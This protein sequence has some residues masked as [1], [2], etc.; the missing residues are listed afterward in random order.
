M[1]SKPYVLQNKLD[2]SFHLS[3]KTS[4]I[5][6]IKNPSNSDEVF[7]IGGYQCTSIFIY[8]TNKH[9]LKTNK[10]DLASLSPE[11]NVAS[12]N[13]YLN[14]KARG[15]QA[16][17]ASLSTTKDHVIVLTAYDRFVLYSIFDCK[18]Y[19]W[20]DLRDPIYDTAYSDH[21]GEFRDQNP[22][23]IVNC[24]VT[25]DT[26]NGV[27]STAMQMNNYCRRDHAFFA[28][29]TSV[30]KYKN[31]LIF[32]GAGVKKNYIYVLD[33]SNEIKP[34][35]IHVSKIIGRHSCV[36]HGCVFFPTIG[37][38]AA[39]N[40]CD[41]DRVDLLIF[42]GLKHTFRSSIYTLRIKFDYA[43]NNKNINSA[44]TG[45]SINDDRINITTEYASISDSNYE[46]K[47]INDNSDDHPSQLFDECLYYFTY[48]WHN[49]WYGR[50]NQYLV[51]F[52]GCSSKR[53]M[54]SR[55]DALNNIILLNT[56]TME[57]K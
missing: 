21:D 28:A 51:I 9:T 5:A 35:I 11:S 6:I 15:V 32:T 24:R 31:Y 29:G 23:A 39:N 49:S 20:I 27:P 18:S 56:T 48:Q 7:L 37:R 46:M 38:N 2:H 57:W 22:S 4:D 40:N 34:R 54:P 43:Q 10:D 44:K 53:T 19:K 3:H 42:G 12:G 36:Y 30:N 26:G 17:S 1:A 47:F 8:N 16:V 33:I 52:G 13:E 25:V 55:G 45:A 50:H 14:S 41:S